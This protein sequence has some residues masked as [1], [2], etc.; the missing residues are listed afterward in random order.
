MIKMIDGIIAIDAHVH[1][2]PLGRKRYGK[3]PVLTPPEML[4]EE[5]DRNGFDKAVIV[6]AGSV[7]PE[8]MRENNDYVSEVVKKWPNR[9]IGFAGICPLLGSVAIEELERAVNVLGLKGIKLYPPHGYPIDSPIVFPIVEKA[10]SL[11]IPIVIHSDFQSLFCNPYQIAR[12]AS[13]YPEATLIMAHMGMHPDLF[14]LTPEIVKPYNNIVLDTSGTPE[15]PEITFVYSIRELGVDRI[16]FGS[17]ALYFD[18]ALALK[19]L[20][21]AKERWGLTEEEKRHILG[22]NMARILRI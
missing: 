1:V 2:H 4:L 9:F 15:C 16:V 14:L 5:M 10:I 8:L 19:K 7:V 12:L 18:Q 3:F 11:N 22:E 6:N 13:L 17:D 20:E 21:R